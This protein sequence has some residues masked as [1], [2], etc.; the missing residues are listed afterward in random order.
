MKQ[1]VLITCLQLQSSIESY[2]HLF[3]EQEIEID[4][5]AVNQQLNA[6][7]LLGIIDRYDGVIAGDDE[8]NEEVLEKAVRLKII[9]RWGV[10]VDAVDLAAAE[11]LG[12]QVVNTPNVFSDEV[13]DIVMGYLILLSRQLHKLDR[14]V[15]NGGW[16]KIRGT[17]LRGKTLGVIGMGSIGRAVAHRGVASGMSILGHDV[18]PIPDSFV[19]ETG[20]RLVDLQELISESD[21]ISLNCNL[22]ASNRHM[23]GELE[24]T[25]MKT[26]VYLVNTARGPLIDELALAKA[27][28]DGRVAGAALDV[29]ETEPLP[30]ESPLR[31]FDSCIFGTHNSSNTSEAVMRVNEIAIRNLLDGL[32]VAALGSSEASAHG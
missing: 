26:G 11:R 13:A 3:E 18:A 9:A 19:R 31:Q 16:T 12:I 23:L 25:S 28:H 15:R 32:A 7:E 24:F 20:S 14:S 30:L 4:L 1:R 10:G 22:T 2:R 29:F 5:P 27:L 8:F 21:F 6:P 17:S